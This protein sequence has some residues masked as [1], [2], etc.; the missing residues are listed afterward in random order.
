MFV[1]VSYDI[2]DDRRRTEIASLLKNFGQ[3]VQKSI[4][5]CYLEEDHMLDLKSS[6]ER[7]IDVA[8]DSV[9]YYYLCKTDEKRVEYF[10][11]TVIYKD[12]DYFMI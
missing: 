5:E 3:R 10:G 9:R 1:I 7:L 6:I 12:E 2:A 8:K 11:E 4:F